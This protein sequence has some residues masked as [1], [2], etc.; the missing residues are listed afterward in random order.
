M[1]VGLNVGGAVEGKVSGV[2][3]KSGAMLA[4]PRLNKQCQPSSFS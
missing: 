3:S 1:K 4:E 2:C